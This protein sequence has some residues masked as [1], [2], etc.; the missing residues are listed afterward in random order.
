[1][2]AFSKQFISVNI[3]DLAHVNL[4]ELFYNFQTARTQ[5]IFGK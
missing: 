4:T 1:M 3:F 5:V 2:L